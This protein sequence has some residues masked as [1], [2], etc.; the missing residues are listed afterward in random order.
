[1]QSKPGA[2]GICPAR[3]ALGPRRHALGLYPID[4]WD[5]CGAGKLAEVW[6]VAGS[7]VGEGGRQ[8]IGW[9]MI[10]PK[11]MGLISRRI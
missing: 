4:G 2:D 6:G 11:G 1:M 9:R 7:G 10:L 8:L 5:G 3:L